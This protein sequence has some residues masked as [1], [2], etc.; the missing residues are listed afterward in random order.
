MLKN[1]TLPGFLFVILSAVI[2][3]FM[4]LMAKYIYND[5]VNPIT[6]VFLRNVLSLPVLAFL[7]KI[8][9]NSLKIEK[10][11]L[12]GISVIALFGCCI[13]PLLLFSSYNYISSG[14]ATVFHFI[15]PAFVV[16]SEIVLRRT[17]AN[18]PN[19]L[20]LIVCAAGILMFYSPGQQLKLAGSILALVSGVTYAIYVLLL[21]GFRHKEISGFRFSLYV[22]LVCSA[23]LLIICIVTGQLHLPKSF[24]GWGMSLFFAVVLNVG[25]VVLFQKGTFLIGGGKASILST[26]EPITSIAA[27]AVFLNEPFSIRTAAGTA[28]VI[29]ASIL[30]SV[31]S[32]VKKQ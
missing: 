18:V 11:A 1:K 22:A 15:Y 28:L 17:K 21:S 10:K 14:T 3:G 27:G 8:T 19:I 9:G 12:P 13:T 6:L 7:V 2:F 30:I 20:S 29:A 24:F 31:P 5:G 4:P 32:I 23:V 25:A 26:F 16:L